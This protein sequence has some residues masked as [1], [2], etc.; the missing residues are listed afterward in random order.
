MVEGARSGGKRLTEIALTFAHRPDHCL[1]LSRH[2]VAL[3]RWGGNAVQRH[4]V[5]GVAGV[6]DLPPS[7]GYSPRHWRSRNEP[8]VGRERHRHQ[9]RRPRRRSRRRCRRV[10]VGQNRHYHARQPPA[11]GALPAR[12]WTNARWLTPRSSFMADETPE[13]RSIDLAK[14]RF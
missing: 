11:S 8:N 10:T 6:P 1:L 2:P 9:R 12:G 3:L 5:G 13:G 7:A 14:Q 4:R